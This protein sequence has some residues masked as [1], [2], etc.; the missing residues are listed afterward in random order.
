MKCCEGE[1][2]TLFVHSVKH[3]CHSNTRRLNLSYF[4]PAEDGGHPLLEV[5][6]SLVGI[7]SHFSQMTRGVSA[8]F[9]GQAAV[10]LVDQ[11]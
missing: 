7:V 3:V 11:L 6:P 8:V 5:V 10:L 4:E 2:D 1:K 9:S